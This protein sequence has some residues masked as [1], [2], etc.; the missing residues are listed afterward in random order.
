M[1]YWQT[2]TNLTSDFSHYNETLIVVENPSSQSRSEFVEI[3]LPYYNFTIHEVKNGSLE[4]VT[5]YDKYLPRTWYNSNKTVVKSYVQM[6]VNFSDVHELYKVF[7]VRNL[8]ILRPKNKPPA[9]YHGDPE[10]VWNLNLPLFMQKEGWEIDVFQSNFK[11]NTKPGTTLKAGS[12]SLQFVKI[13]GNSATKGNKT[14]TF[15]NDNKLAEDQTKKNNATDSFKGKN[16]RK[17]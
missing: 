4:N 16:K 1:D 11:K 5:N 2:L 9:T 6:H 13:M 10:R 7:V 8:G 15:T 17:I 14:V 3:Q 12:R